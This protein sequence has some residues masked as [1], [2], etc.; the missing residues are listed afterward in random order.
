MLTLTHRLS[1]PTPAH[2]TLSLTAEERSRSRHYFEAE[3]DQGMY[4]QLPRGT[5]LRQGDLL[6]SEDGTTVVQVIAKPE[7][8][9][10]VTAPTSLQLLRAAY[11]LG[12]R[13]VPLEVTA[14]YLQ[15]S[16]DSVLKA[17]LEQLGLQV[18]EQVLPF[19]PETGAYGRAHHASH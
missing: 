10:V 1:I 16:P 15:F 9:M 12:N 19:E 5:V 18:S 14:D 3:L 2:L 4:L 6:Q 17:M 8:V 11:H 7:P 13:H